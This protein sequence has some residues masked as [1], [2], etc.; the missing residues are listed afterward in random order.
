MNLFSPQEFN[1]ASLAV[2]QVLRFIH[3]TSSRMT[4]RERFFLSLGLR[5]SHGQEAKRRGDVERAHVHDKQVQ[6]HLLMMPRPITERDKQLFHLGILSTRLE[7]A[8]A[9]GETVSAQ[10]IGLQLMT[11]IRSLAP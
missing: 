6:K 7:E 3:L 5:V 4:K 11:F 9:H 10:Q 1:E 8:L 2:A